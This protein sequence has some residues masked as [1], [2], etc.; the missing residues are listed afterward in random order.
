MCSGMPCRF[1]P[2]DGTLPRKTRVSL[3]VY[4]LLGQKVAD[5]V[6]FLR[7]TAGSALEAIARE[8]AGI[9]KPGVP[10][11]VHALYDLWALVYLLK[12]RGRRE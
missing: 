1:K 10:A 12:I 3:A 8:K 7:L 11:V 9:F 5:L 2:P 4:T 6:E